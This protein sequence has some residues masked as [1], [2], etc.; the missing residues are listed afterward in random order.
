MKR[1]IAC[2]GRDGASDAE[3]R[4]DAAASLMSAWLAELLVGVIAALLPSMVAST[5]A[6]RPFVRDELVAL[7]IEEARSIRIESLARAPNVEV[8]AT[9]VRV[10]V[11]F[12]IWLD[13]I[14][15]VVAP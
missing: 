7:V 13:A 11:E 8:D 4:R 3:L 10:L 12:A 2:M 1:V 6:M 14:V 15:I 9:F 5:N